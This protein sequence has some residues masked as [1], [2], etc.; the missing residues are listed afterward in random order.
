M[1]AVRK[2]YVLRIATNPVVYVWTGNG[3]LDTPADAVDL[4][5]ATWR[6][7]GRIIQLPALKA[8]IN[9]V[10]ERVG[11]TLSGVSADTLRLAQEDKD[12]VDGA[13]VRIGSVEFD[14]QWQLTGPIAWEWRGTADT[15]TVESAAGEDGSRVRTIA[16]SVAAIDNRRANPRYTFWTDAA[17]RLRSSDD[18][19]CD[20]VAQI[21]NS[22]SRRFGPQ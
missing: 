5:G 2:S 8:L 16:L 20:H 22:V 10:S 15:L 11:F 1:T 13:D 4:S 17:Q 21:S 3:L 9:G 14:A 18:A 6:G 12:E 19:F 7:A